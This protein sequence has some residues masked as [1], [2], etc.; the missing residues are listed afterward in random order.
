MK[1]DSFLALMKEVVE[2]DVEIMREF[3]EEEIQP[4]ILYR[5]ELERK[6]FNRAYDE[7]LEIEGEV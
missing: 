4:L 2:E 3:I 1:D 5:Q 6:L 7:L